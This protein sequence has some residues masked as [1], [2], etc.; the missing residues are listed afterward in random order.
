MYGMINLH[1]VLAGSGSY[2]IGRGSPGGTTPALVDGLTPASSIPIRGV[3]P[4]VCQRKISKRR[5]RGTRG[6]DPGRERPCARDRRRPAG[7]TDDRCS[8]SAP[9]R[10]GRR[11]KGE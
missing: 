7:T 8:T 6:L 4:I 2:E 9:S 10:G 5:G 1:R 3:A 11:E